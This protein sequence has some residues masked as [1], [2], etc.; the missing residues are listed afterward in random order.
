MTKRHVKLL[1]WNI[2]TYVIY[3]II[4]FKFLLINLKWL[5]WVKGFFRE[6]WSM[7]PLSSLN[8]CEIR[9]KLLLESYNLL[10]YCWVQFLEFPICH[11]SIVSAVK[12]IAKNGLF[13]VWKGALWSFWSVLEQWKKNTFLQGFFEAC[14]FFPT[15]TKQYPVFVGHK[16]GR[17]NTQRHKMDI[18]QIMIM[19]RTL[20]IA[21]RLV[22]P[23]S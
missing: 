19:N 12:D 10:M 9:C 3:Q 11:L 14:I 6:S 2:S 20:Y 13:F 16:P 15:D 22:N 17:N 5:L 21:A 18:Q 8:F 4:S 1:K 23:F 7:K